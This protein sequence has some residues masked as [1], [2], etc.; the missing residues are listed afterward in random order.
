MTLLWKK[1]KQITFEDLSGLRARRYV[2]DSDPDQRNGFG[3]D[4][5]LHN[6]ERFAQSCGLVLDSRC[7]TEFVTV[8]C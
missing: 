8:Q 4:I 2:R 5:Q 1:N 3:P 6:E 7:Y